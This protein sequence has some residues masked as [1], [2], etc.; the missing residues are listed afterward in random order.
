MISQLR[1]SIHDIVPIACYRALEQKTRVG[2]LSSR[3]ISLP[4]PFQI[5]T[6]SRGC[7]YACF[8]L[9]FMSE[10]P[11]NLENDVHTRKGHTLSQHEKH[12]RYADSER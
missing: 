2:D 4:V 5:W 7:V 12:V 9:L 3:K 11:Q 10:I 8:A 6:R 1:I